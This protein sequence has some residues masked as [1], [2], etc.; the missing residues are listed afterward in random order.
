VTVAELALELERR[1]ADAERVGATAPVASVLRTVLEDL[2]A[3]DGANPADPDDRLLRVGE[4]AAMLDVSEWWVYM[5]AKTLPF[6]RKVGPR[7]LR[8]SEKGARRW[9]LR[10][11][12]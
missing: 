6:A 3:V 1:I 4:V 5:H 2:R 11:A 9:L 8:F 7:S 10:R 12:S